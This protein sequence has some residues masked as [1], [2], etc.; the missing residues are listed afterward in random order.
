MAMS[1]LRIVFVIP[2]VLVCSTG[3]G[4]Q[5][6]NDTLSDVDRINGLAG[7]L[8]HSDV[9]TSTAALDALELFR[10]S[11]SWRIRGATDNALS[12]FADDAKVWLKD[13]A[14]FVKQSPD[15]NHRGVVDIA[16]IDSKFDPEKLV[17]LKVFNISSLGFVDAPQ[18]RDK[19]LVCLGGQP[20]L[21]SL[22]FQNTGI[23]GFGFESVEIPNL[24]VA[25]LNG[26]PICDDG[27]ACI[28]TKRF[29]NLEQIVVVDTE[30]TD[31]GLD[32]YQEKNA[33]LIRRTRNK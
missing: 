30:I 15:E 19:H 12:Q 3:L 32:Q 9:N 22:T 33:V 29:P 21:K 2:F 1:I 18:L 20:R 4:Q 6:Q 24:E 17:Y 11:A 26:S 5:E 16:F 25:F 28:S 13:N 10:T 7:L 31:Q 23:Q 8:N 27:V 14:T